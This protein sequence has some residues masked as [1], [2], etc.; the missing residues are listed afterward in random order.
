[1]AGHADLAR[2]RES[3]QVHFLEHLRSE[4]RHGRAVRVFLRALVRKDGQRTPAEP[5][6]E[7]GNSRRGIGAAT[8][9]FGRNIPTALAR[10]VLGR[11]AE[12]VVERQLGDMGH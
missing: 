4:F 11:D 8:V 5:G 3:A 6:S 2:R 10:N 12:I 7:I 9:D 1:M